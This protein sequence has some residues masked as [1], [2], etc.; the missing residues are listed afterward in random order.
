MGCNPAQGFTFTPK[1]GFHSSMPNA[2]V[3]KRKRLR[4][5]VYARFSSDNQRDIS[6]ADQFAEADAWAAANDVDIVGYYQDFALTG[7]NDKR[8]DFQRMMREIDGCDIVIIWKTD[9]LHRN[10][11]N[12]FHYLGK[13]LDAGKDFVSLKQPELNND[14]PTR[15]LLFAIYAWKDERYSADLSTDVKRGMRGN[16]KRGQYLGYKKYGFSHEG[17][18]ITL[19]HTEAEVVLE[20]FIRRSNDAS[21]VSIRRWM[22]SIGVRTTRGNEPSDHFVT[23]MLQDEWYMGVYIWDD[24]RIDGGVPAIVSKEL[25]MEVQETF[26]RKTREK[27]DPEL[28]LSGKLVCADC[29]EYMHGE[30]AKGGKYLYYCCRGKR[31]ACRGNINAQELND[32]VIKAIRNMFSDYETCARLVEQWQEW[33]EKLNDRTDIQALEK[34]LSG[35]RTKRK[36]LIDAIA[37]GLPME[38]AAEPLEELTKQETGTLDRIAEAESRL[39]TIDNETLFELLNYIREGNLADEDVLDAF[40][41]EVYVYADKVVIVSNITDSCSNYLEVEAALEQLEPANDDGFENLPM[42]E[43]RGIEPLTS[44]LPAM[45]SPS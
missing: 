1:G 3:P 37:N 43:H 26:K 4:G 14:S 40:A 22:K 21:I 25:F 35:I 29:G 34:Q 41:C 9:R 19:N 5:Y 17:S 39:V 44:W 12:A 28:F 27:K 13:L 33:N 10:I 23:A 38:D 42:V 31:K 36:N 32:V 6:N 7:R 11:F 45:R 16:A 24:I 18:T 8:P 20:A 2:K 30:R 15:M